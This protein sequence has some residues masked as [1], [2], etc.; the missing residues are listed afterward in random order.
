[1]I[2]PQA[3]DVAARLEGILADGLV[4][5]YLHGSAVLDCFGPRSD[6]D[7]V[8]V[9]SRPTT[10]REQRALVDALLEISVPY[11][12]SGPRRPVELDLVVSSA[13]D[14]WQYPTPF[15][16]LYGESHRSRFEAGELTPWSGETNKDL[17]AHVTVL[18]TAGVVLRGPPIEEMFPKVPW[19]DYAD[20]L[21]HDLDW[22]RTRFAEEPR[23]GVLSIA[24]IWAT[25][26]TGT[27]HSKATGADWALPRLAAD[28]RPVLDHG[29]DLYTGAE[30]EERWASLP[31][32]SYVT[33]VA[34]E[35]DRLG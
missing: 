22:C 8:A 6:V 11:D 34:S 13:L 17:A 30:D 5:V 19:A 27:V 32:A 29:R 24:R 14:P 33:A 10:D 7:L 1:M 26:A 16:F 23:Y 21:T 18:R 3:E 25:L 20:A 31:V 9:A 15:D 12:A 35:I 4:G 2:P 28:L